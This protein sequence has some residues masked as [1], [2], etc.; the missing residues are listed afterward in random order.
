MSRIT[1][2]HQVEMELKPI[3]TPRYYSR[4]YRI[5]FVVVVVVVVVVVT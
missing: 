3:T 1:I 5:S 2:L 4:V